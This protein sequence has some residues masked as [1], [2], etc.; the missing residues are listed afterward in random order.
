MVKCTVWGILEMAPKMVVGVQYNSLAF[1]YISFQIA[2]SH[3]CRFAAFWKRLLKLM[4]VSRA[5]VILKSGP[6][7]SF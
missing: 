2:H 1:T 7:F 3:L 6:K 5:I 4:M